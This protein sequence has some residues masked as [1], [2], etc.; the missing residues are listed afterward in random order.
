MARYPSDDQMTCCG[1]QGARMRQLA[2]IA[3]VIKGE[4]TT[5]PGHNNCIEIAREEHRRRSREDELMC[6]RFTV[7]HYAAAVARGIIDPR[8]PDPE[9][10][11]DL[12]FVQQWLEDMRPLP[13]EI[14]ASAVL[15]AIDALP[16]H[17]REQ[18]YVRTG[19][20]HV[21][22]SVTGGK[23]PPRNAT[24]ADLLISLELGS[25]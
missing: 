9:E 14:L 2:A 5:D 16:Y 1:C 22:E 25:R 21:I 11:G 4:P 23:I 18:D 19:Y 8:L 12:D 13:A 20:M 17:T 3:H 10:H 6:L 7:A 15:P 24:V